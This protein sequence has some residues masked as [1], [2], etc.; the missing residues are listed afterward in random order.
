MPEALDHQRHHIEAALEG[1]ISPG[2]LSCIRLA[3]GAAH[4]VA[5]PGAG[6]ATAIERVVAV[7]ALESVTAGPADHQVIT[8]T[9]DETVGT[10]RAENQAGK[11][12][13]G[14][15]GGDDVLQRGGERLLRAEHVVQHADRALYQDKAVRKKALSKNAGDRQK[16]RLTKRLNSI[17]AGPEGLSSQSLL[18]AFWLLVGVLGILVGAIRSLAVLVMAPEHTGWARNET[19]VQLVMLGAGIA[20]LFVLGIFPQIMRPFLDGLPLIFT[21]LSQ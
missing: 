9:S 14:E 2:E 18:L 8:R 4:T 13:V 6:A 20:I 10:V 3:D 19:W 1:E 15:T 7:T 5:G 17:S 11:I 21:H 16:S 12:I